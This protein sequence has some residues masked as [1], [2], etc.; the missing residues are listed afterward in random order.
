MLGC[1]VTCTK[2]NCTYIVD[3]VSTLSWCF[4]MQNECTSMHTVCRVNNYVL[5]CVWKDIICQSN[6]HQ[7]LPCHI[8]SI[9]F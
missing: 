6:A 5:C 9:I 1:K 7:T 2:L 8:K 4:I 3:E